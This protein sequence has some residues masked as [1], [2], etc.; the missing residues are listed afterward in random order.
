MEE[1]PKVKFNGQLR[2]SQQEVVQIAQKKLKGGKKRLHIVA[3]P[4][5]GKTVLGLYLW[6]ECISR[7]AVVLS[8]NSA[9]QAQWAA[10]TDLFLFD[11]DQPD[12]PQ[13]R[14]WVSTSSSQPSSLTSLTYQSVTMPQRGSDNLDEQ[15]ERLWQQRLVEENQAENDDEAAVWIHDLKERNE[16]YY[17]K[18]LATYRKKIRDEVSIF[19]NSLD[20][21]HD[22]SLATLERLKSMNVGLIILDECHHLM[23][24]WGRVLADAKE[25]LGDPHVIGLT[26]TP[27]DRGGKKSEDINRYDDFFGEV[28]FEVPVPAVVKDGF[29]AP[30][31][32]LAY[33]VRPSAQELEFVATTDSQLADLVEELCQLRPHESPLELEVEEESNADESAAESSE[34]RK[35]VETIDDADDSTDRIDEQMVQQIMRANAN[36]DLLADD[37]MASD[38]TLS[39]EDQEPSSAVDSGNSSGVQDSPDESVSLLHWLHEALETR[40]LSTTT[41]K[42]WYSFERRDETF[43]NAARKFLQRRKIKLPRSVPPLDAE[44]VDEEPTM[45]DLIPVLD[46]YVRHALRRSTDT[47]DHRLAESATQRLRMLGVQITETGSQACASPVGRVLAYSKNKAAALPEIL[48]HEMKCLGD[49]IRAVVV[50]D[51]EKSSATAAEVGEILDEESGGAIAAFRTLVNNALTDQLDPILLTGSSVLVDDD[52]VESFFDQSGKWLQENGFEVELSA[53]QQDG[54]QVIQGSGSDW[55]PRVY[56]EMITELFQRGITKCLVG[57]RGLLGEGWDANKINVLIDLTTVTTS[58]TVNQLRGRSI[59]LDPEMKNKLANNWDVICIAPEFTKGLDDY[60][61]FE[62]KHKT[63]YG[64]TD[65]GAIEKGVGHVHAA[66][67]ELKPAGI[68]GSVR[69]LNADMLKRV[70]NRD[71]VRQLWKIGQPYE[72]KPIKTI[73]ARL[74]QMDGKD[75]P[76]FTGEKD[77]WNQKSLTTA[78]GRAI[79]FAL[80]EANVIRKTSSIHLGE[81]DGGFIRMFLQDATEQE[82]QI[83]VDALHETLGPLKDPRYII[84][85][86]VSR[87]VD[88]WLSKILPSVV[89]RFFQKEKKVRVMF[90]AVPTV[91]SKNRSKVSI[92]EQGWN[93]FVSPG[94][95]VFTQRGT[96]EELLAKAKSIGKRNSREVHNKE[97]FL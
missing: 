60:K 83:F 3:P 85:R 76:P 27:P 2:P 91:L 63:L 12:H 43:A 42:D 8:P 73:E 75:F 36:P 64:V 49:A 71:R 59:R 77:P 44:L 13:I 23:G 66:F 90:H 62:K 46:R 32:D 10:R 50:T 74:G 48:K 81:R 93:A 97:I 57:T 80:T 17:E 72:N 18:R 53:S 86:V 41:I 65:D 79:L 26:A 84:P 67:T 25:L 52:A 11:P 35:R 69:L 55:C 6:A 34:S 29:L 82:N 87:K 22:S 19:G 4:G 94:D 30:Y 5:S 31:Q 96:G 88:T 33:F 39:G 56:V 68:E 15:A 9:I 45:D 21:L 40:R 38:G 7:P 47:A 16:D 61:R 95:A 89:G 58:M 70:D 54:F 37:T 28:D 51:F 78:I 14:E 1:F 20:V 92:F 24:H